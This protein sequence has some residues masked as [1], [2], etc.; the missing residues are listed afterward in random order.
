MSTRYPTCSKASSERSN[1]QAEASPREPASR[2]ASELDSASLHLLG[3]TNLPE[4]LKSVTDEEAIPV[5]IRQAPRGD[6]RQRAGKE[7]SRNLRDPLGLKM[8]VSDKSLSAVEVGRLHSSEEWPNPPGAKGGDCKSATIGKLPLLDRTIHNTQKVQSWKWKLASELVTVQ[9]NLA[10]KPDAGN[11][12]VR[13]D[14]GECRDWPLPPPCILYS[15]QFSQSCQK[16]TARCLL[17]RHDLQDKQDLFLF[18]I[19]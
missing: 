8:S 16:T 2:N 14:E 11:L 4:M 5:C 3:V 19:S 9:D 17:V 15:T 10:G 18:Y 12:H 6:W 1:P 7:K 13:F